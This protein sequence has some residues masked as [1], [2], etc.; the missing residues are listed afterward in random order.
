MGDFYPDYQKMNFE[1]LFEKYSAGELIFKNIYKI[2]VRRIDAL[3]ED[4]IRN[5][6]VRYSPHNPG[7]KQRVMNL[8]SQLYITI[9]EIVE[10]F[11]KKNINVRFQGT[12]EQILEMYLIIVRHLEDIR[13]RER[14][15]IHGFPIPENDI[16]ALY[17]ICEMLQQQRGISNIYGH[18]LESRGSTPSHVKDHKSLY[19]YFNTFNQKPLFDRGTH[20][21]PLGY[22]E[23]LPHE[24]LADQIQDIKEG[25][26]HRSL[27]QD[28]PWRK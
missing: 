28:P 7:D 24:G 13:E 15:R 3:G 17:V 16:R 1:R 25:F 12:V 26:H 11:I 5:G 14:T 10:R 6:L 8:C 21:K 9:N 18:Y 20:S 27:N 4:D 19:N 22:S 2:E 23:K